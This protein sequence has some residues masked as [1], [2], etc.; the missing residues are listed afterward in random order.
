MAKVSHAFRA[1][2]HRSNQEAST[3]PIRG[4][5]KPAAAGFV[6]FDQHVVANHARIGA[7][8]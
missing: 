1:G 7:K 6:C 3:F 4:K 5:T 8:A 2:A